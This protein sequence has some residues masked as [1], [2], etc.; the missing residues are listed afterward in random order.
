[1]FCGFV[2]ATSLSAFY[3]NYSEGAAITDQVLQRSAFLIWQ[4]DKTL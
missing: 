3:R 2:T 4:L 1:M